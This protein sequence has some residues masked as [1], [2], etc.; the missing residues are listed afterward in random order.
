MKYELTRFLLGFMTKNGFV[1]LSIFL[2]FFLVVCSIDIPLYLFASS[3]PHGGCVRKVPGE[4][5]LQDYMLEAI[6]SNKME[7]LSSVGNLFDFHDANPLPFI[8]NAQNISYKL[9]KE[10]QIL[11]LLLEFQGE[12]GAGPIHNQIP[13]PPSTDVRFWVP[14][15]SQKH[16]QKMLFNRDVRNLSMA[17][18]YLETSSGRYTVGGKVYGW[19]GLPHSESYYGEDKEGDAYERDSA[20]GPVWRIIEDAAPVIGNKIN[21]KEFD[22]IDRF[23]WDEDGNLNEPD[24][25]VDH[26]MIVHAGMGQ[27]ADEG[28]EGSHAIWSHRG[29]AR[30]RP[31]GLAERIGPQHY[32]ARG[33]IQVDPE[34]DIWILDYTMLPED[35]TVGTS[36]HE[37]AHDLGLS[38]LYDTHP[39]D[40]SES[41]VGFWSIMASGSWTTFPKEPLGLVPTHFSAWEKMKLGWLDYEEIVLSKKDIHKFVLLDRS[42]FHGQKAQGLRIQLPDQEKVISMV[43]AIEG[44]AYAYSEKGNEMIHRF[45]TDIDLSQVSVATLSFKT[46][47]EIEPDYDYAYV[48]I[49]NDDGKLVPIHG[50]ISKDSNPNG[51]NL[52]HGITASSEGKWLDAIFDLKPYVGRKRRLGFTYITDASEGGMGFLIDDLKIPEIKFEENF[53]GPKT[54]KDRWKTQGFVHVSNGE[55]K[56]KF[57]HAYFLEWRTHE[58]FDRALNSVYYSKVREGEVGYFSYQPGLLLWYRNEFYEEGDNQ[59]GEHPGEGALLVVDARAKPE[60]WGEKVPFSTVFQLHDAAFGFEKSPRYKIET[61][62]PGLLG[63]T[64]AISVFH[65]QFSFYSAEMPFNSVKLPTYGLMFSLLNTS[66]DNS[67]VQM[68]IHYSNP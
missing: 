44:A 53:E 61:F 64:Q 57:S 68:A 3:S 17:N 60:W 45:V 43:P 23:D 59:V 46:F 18:Y 56:K 14:D 63:G 6:Q 67:A 38:D 29:R 35:G 16:Y 10:S 19:F 41:S 26:V 49:E 58:G 30:Y 2:R 22:T 39:K 40:G 28:E 65:D 47:Y 54:F 11:V 1:V 24:G 25:Y 5:K 37:F 12:N 55:I 4:E 52:G 7:T 50:N 9:M 32:M 51:Q 48:E 42:F 36:S 20:N 8:S 62:I 66:P 27:E 15:F 31:P 13:K 21:W 33:G 34:N